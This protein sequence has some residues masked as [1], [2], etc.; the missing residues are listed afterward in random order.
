MIERK[1]RIF[2]KGRT[3]TKASFGDRCRELVGAGALQK[4][5]ACARAR[6]S[7]SPLTVTPE[8]SRLGGEQRS[9]FPGHLC[10]RVGAAQRSSCLPWHG[11]PQP[12]ELWKYPIWWFRDWAEG[13][14]RKSTA[15]SD[16]QV[17]FSVGFRSWNP[18][19]QESSLWKITRRPCPQRE[20]YTA[21]LWVQRNLT[22]QDGFTVG[23]EKVMVSGGESREEESERRAR[24]KETEHIPVGHQG[25]AQSREEL[26][27]QLGWCSH[28]S[29]S[30]SARSKQF[31]SGKTWRSAW[32]CN[33]CP[34]SVPSTSSGTWTRHPALLQRQGSPKAPR[35]PTS[36]R[37][38][39]RPC[40][41]HDS[42]D[43][44]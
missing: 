5:T 12:G 42:L 14:V 44:C 11:Q 16:P 29:Q 2:M 43:S 19:W 9:D 23:R 22:G 32:P 3:K 10:F 15:R 37:R 27:P 35:L 13:C 34:H 7:L 26:E 33:S 31:S 36:L 20:C 18:S 6:H 17:S 4:P 24:K 40:W 8:R 38:L 30:K 1:K 28:F 41:E 39:H 21:T 25:M